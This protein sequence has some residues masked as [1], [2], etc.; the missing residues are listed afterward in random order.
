MAQLAN[1][2]VAYINGKIVPESQALVS[3]RDRSFL[4]GDAVFDM[5]RTFGHK[6]FKLQ[7]HIDRFYRSPDAIKQTKGAGLGLYLAKAI[8]E[9]HGGSIRLVQG[10]GGDISALVHLPVS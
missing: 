10:D 8:V 2:R 5:T 4:Y 3:F 6:V 1:E 9:A 7:E